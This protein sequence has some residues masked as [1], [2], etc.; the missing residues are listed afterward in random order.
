MRLRSLAL[1][2]SFCSCNPTVGSRARRASLTVRS[3]CSSRGLRAVLAAAIRRLRAGQ[4][5]QCR[6]W[7]YGRHD[8]RRS[9]HPRLQTGDPEQSLL[10]SYELRASQHRHRLRGWGGGSIVWID[11]GGGDA[12]DPR[13]PPPTRVPHAMAAAVPD[14]PYRPQSRAWPAL[15]T[16]RTFWGDHCWDA[17][18]RRGACVRRSSVMLTSDGVPEAGE[19]CLV[20]PATTYCMAAGG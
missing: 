2:A 11:A 3:C 12:S 20:C 16:R 9:A 14:R 6:F 13:A 4:P 5:A 1:P 18:R 10:H 17:E 7:R 19:Q 8:V 15:S